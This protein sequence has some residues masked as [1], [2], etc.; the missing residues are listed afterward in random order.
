MKTDIKHEGIWWSYVATCDRCGSFIQGHGWR[1]T[2]EPDTQETDFC[3]DCLKYLL[4]NN[5]SY[6]DAKKQYKQGS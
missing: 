4:Y 5:I 3:L 1:Q 6:E 2:D